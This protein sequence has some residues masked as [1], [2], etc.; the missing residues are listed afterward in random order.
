VELTPRPE[1]KDRVDN[2]DDGRVDLDDLECAGD[3]NGAAE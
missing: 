3:P 1:C 2:D